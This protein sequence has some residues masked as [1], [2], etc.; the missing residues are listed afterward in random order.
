MSQQAAMAAPPPVQ[1]PAMA[2]M[3]GTRQRSTAFRMRSMVTSYWMPSSGVENERN[4]EM[5]VPAAKAFSPMPVRISTRM[6]G[7]SWASAQIS[8][9]R[10][11]IGKVSALRACGRLK[12]M[13]PMPS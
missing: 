4:C 2:A 1:A 7:S 10:S 12:V 13:R 5:S 9:R 11:Y 3:V 8:A 6:D